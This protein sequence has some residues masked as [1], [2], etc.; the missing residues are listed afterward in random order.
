MSGVTVTRMAGYTKLFSRILDSTI[1]REDDKTRILWITML[2]MTDQDGIVQCT[3]PG[4]ADRARIT[5]KECEDALERFQT[6]DKY[7]WSKEDE[8]R[9][10]RAVEGGWFLINHAK[11][12]ALMSQEEQREKTRLRV[13]RW[14]EKNALPNV[15]NVTRNESNDIAD[16]KAYTDSKAIKVRTFVHPTIEEIASYCQ[17]RKNQIDPQQFLDFYT[18]NGWKVGRNAMKDWRASVRTWEKN[19]YQKSQAKETLAER[20]RRALSKV[21]GRPTDEHGPAIR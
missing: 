10:V 21:F 2:A 9:R 13:Q 19:G 17:E 1:W 14:R 20:N 4:L 3:I 5:I 16:S 8:G 6:P 18:A 12:R 7:S 15:T 11:Y